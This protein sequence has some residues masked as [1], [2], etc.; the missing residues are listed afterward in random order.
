MLRQRR[1]LHKSKLLGGG[2]I[3]N[4]SKDKADAAHPF[5]GLL[6]PPKPTATATMASIYILLFATREC[7]VDHE[8]GDRST[9]PGSES[10]WAQLLVT[11]YVPTDGF[12][13]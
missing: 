8:G 1:H 12:C 11:F 5:A 3:N 6:L 2:A 7:C 4:K 9:L 13:C 10:L